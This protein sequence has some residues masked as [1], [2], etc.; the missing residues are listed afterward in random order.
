MRITQ[1]RKG[2]EWSGSFEGK[3]WTGHCTTPACSY[4][5]SDKS[6]RAAMAER[7]RNIV[8]STGEGG[9]GWPE[10]WCGAGDIVSKT[11]VVKLVAE[12]R[13]AVDCSRRPAA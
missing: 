13:T 6:A 10:L 2:G 9:A 1:R 11:A 4:V 7:S 5:P 12:D 3:P 8:A